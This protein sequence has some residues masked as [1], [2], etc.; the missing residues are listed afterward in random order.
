MSVYASD[1]GVNTLTPAHRNLV[2]VPFTCI[3][4]LLGYTFIALWRHG[5]CDYLYY[6]KC[7]VNCVWSWCSRHIL[8]QPP[9]QY[10]SINFIPYPNTRPLFFPLFFLCL[11]GLSSMLLSFIPVRFVI[12]AHIHAM[13]LLCI[14]K[15]STFNIFSNGMFYLPLH[16]YY[17]NCNLM[18]T[19][20]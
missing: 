2:T 12:F 10:Y 5:T 13:L 3:C 8:H 14:P 17:L 15:C 19:S 11:N 1:Y 6:N 18:C 16:A 7:R 4:A 20:L 9:F